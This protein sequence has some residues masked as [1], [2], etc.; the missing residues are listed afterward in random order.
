MLLKHFSHGSITQNGYI[1]TS[2]DYAHRDNYYVFIVQE[3]GEN[4]LLVD[5]KEYRLQGGTMVCILPG[6]VHGGAK[7][8]D[9]AGWLLA[10]D[11][12]FV[13]EE[14]K[15]VFEKTLFTGNLVTPDEE[16]LADLLSCITVLNRKLCAEHQPLHHYVSSSL[17]TSFVSLAAELYESHQPAGA[18]K[19]RTIITRRFKALLSEN[20]LSVKTPSQ[21]AA[22]LY[23][24]PP[25]LN[26]AVKSVTGCT[27]SYWIQYEIALAAKR[28]LFYTDMSIKEISFHLGYEDCG[29]FT[30]L[31]GKIAG[32]S[33]AQFRMIYRK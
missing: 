24:S 28:L 6:Q 15:E 13:K 26:E 27:S 1:A 17:A 14:M 31:F 10:L 20:I 16:S 33:P 25:Y 3:S 23:I 29:Y 8:A 12:L 19:R 9:G 18:D 7:Q 30:R 11:A 32:T 4:R 5:F 21:Y 22:L 2:V